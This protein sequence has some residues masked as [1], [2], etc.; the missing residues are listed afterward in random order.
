[1]NGAGSVH[2]RAVRKTKR[3]AFPILAARAVMDTIRC[4][5]V[6]RMGQRFGAADNKKPQQ[7]L[8]ITGVR[9]EKRFWTV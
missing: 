9:A 3:I 1:M 8:R 2:R 7:S 6:N 4:G 5:G